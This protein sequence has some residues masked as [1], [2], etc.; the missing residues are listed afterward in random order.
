MADIKK[1]REAVVK[2]RGGFENA[3]D[4]DI[5]TIWRLL[6]DETQ[7]AYL[8]SIKTERKGKANADNQ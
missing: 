7:R 4:A 1:I 2:N 8:E 5:M 6:D 3:P